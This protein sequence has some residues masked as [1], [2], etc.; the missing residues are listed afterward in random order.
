MSL[1]LMVKGIIIYSHIKFVLLN[2]FSFRYIKVK[3]GQRLDDK[4]HKVEGQLTL[5]EVKGTE[6]LYLEFWVE[7]V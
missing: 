2:V 5:F 4:V 3:G 7:Y 1:T 6:S